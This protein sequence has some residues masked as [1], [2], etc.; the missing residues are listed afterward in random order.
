M[1]NAINRRICVKTFQELI[2]NF[3]KEIFSSDFF[4]IVRIARF[5]KLIFNLIIT[6][7]GNPNAFIN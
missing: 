7:N 1:Q 3:E 5:R 4:F 2:R 6:L